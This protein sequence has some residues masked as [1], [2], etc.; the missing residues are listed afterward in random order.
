MY[1]GTRMCTR[2]H[3]E[4]QCSQ[5]CQAFHTSE[6]VVNGGS[7]VVL[8]LAVA[9]LVYL[10]VSQPALE[11]VSGARSSS[12]V[13]GLLHRKS[14]H[15]LHE[16]LILS[17]LLLCTIFIVCFLL[18]VILFFVENPEH[19][20]DVPEFVL[21]GFVG[22]LNASGACVHGNA[23]RQT[24]PSLTACSQVRIHP[25]LSIPPTLSRTRQ[26]SMPRCRSVC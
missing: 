8:C 7:L 9:T 5:A 10:L 18:S 12:V 15:H 11:R 17:I 4:L 2:V 21:T 20:N 22:P 1:S 19:S 3:A 23:Y 24:L 13:E 6:P 25:P 14:H 16:R 26:S